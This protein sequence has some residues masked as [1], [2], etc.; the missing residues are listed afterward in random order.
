VAKV[1]APVVFEY[2][3]DFVVREAELQK[4]ELDICETDLVLV[5]G[6]LNQCPAV[7]IG[8][9]YRKP[10]G[11]LGWVTSV[12]VTAYLRSRGLEGYAFLDHDHLN[13]F[14]TLLQVRK[15]FRQTRML[16]VTQGN[17]FPSVGVVSS[18][19]DLAG[20]RDRVVEVAEG[21]TLNDLAEQLCREYG[22][23]FRHQMET[24]Q[25][26]R[27]LVNGRE[28]EVLQGRETALNEGDT[29]TFFPLV[30]GG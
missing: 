10:V 22:A 2:H 23:D 11:L 9:R 12:D 25:G 3:D 30:F 13:R 28:N 27:I 8:E 18:I 4:L 19:T 5:S 29:V 16:I 24:S 21:A 7:A 6:G 20:V 26:L 14:L 1:L 15:A 17:S